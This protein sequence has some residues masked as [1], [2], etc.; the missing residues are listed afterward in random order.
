MAVI[1]A[2]KILYNMCRAV[3]Y[4]N[5]RVTEENNASIFRIKV[6]AFVKMDTASSSETSI[7]VNESI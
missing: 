6:T 3:W 5:T 7:P 1:M 2:I 4:T